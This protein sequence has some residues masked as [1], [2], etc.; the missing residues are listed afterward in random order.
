[1]VRLTIL[2][3]DDDE[4]DAFFLR[5]AVEAC[6]PDSRIFCVSDGEQALDYLAGHGRYSDREAYPPPD[7]LLLDVKMPKL[8]GFEVL[9]WLRARPQLVGLKVAILSGSQ[10]P[11]DMERARK[12]GA[13]YL[14][15]PLEYAALARVVRE[16]L[17][18]TAV[19]A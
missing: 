2:I 14:V 4:S 5:R 3:A 1:M 7:R 18:I 17:Q 8:G 16:Y 10:L 19:S 9:E 6:A 15:K 11:D 13:A 12:W